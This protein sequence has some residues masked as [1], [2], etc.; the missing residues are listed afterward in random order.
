[1]FS[2][3][4][5]ALTEKNSFFRQEIVT[6]KYC[7][8]VVM[9]INPGEDIGTEI[10][11]GDQIL[12][13]IE[14]TGEAIIN[15]IRSPI[16]PGVLSFVPAGTEHNFINTGASAL[17]LFTIYAPPQHKPGTVHETKADAAQEE[18]YAL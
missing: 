2:K 13:F 3:D 5:F 6:H 16:L 14:G 18:P 9:S 7:Q 11:N 12:V 17:K 4:I 1:M 10:H 8:V 15:G